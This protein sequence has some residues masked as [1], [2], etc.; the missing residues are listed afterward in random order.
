MRT[1]ASRGEA[2]KKEGKTLNPIVILVSVVI[3][4]TIASYFVFPGM[5]NRT[6]LD[7][8]TV[9][10]AGSY[11]PV[12]KTPVGI[13]EMFR[14]IPEGLV[15]SGSLIWLVLLVGGALKVYTE[16]GS[17]DKGISRFLKLS[18]KVGSQVV[19][20][21]IIIVFALI[22]GFLGWSEQIIPFAPI[23]TAICLS[24]GYDAVV[25]MASAWFVCIIAFSVSPTNMFTVA[26]CQQV[27]ELPLFSGM[28]LRLIILAVFEILC[29]VYILRY[30]AKIKKDPTKSI[31]YDIDNT[32]LRRDYSKVADEKMTVRQ[33]L[34]L[35]ILGLTFV[36]SI[37]MVLAYGWGMNDLATAFLISGLAAGIVCSMPFAKIVTSFADGAKDSFYGALII[38]VARAIQIVLEKGHLVDTIVNVLSNGLGG[39]PA[40]LTAIGVF[41]VVTLINGL[42]PSGSAKAI[43]LMPILV[44]LA[45]MVG[46]TR[47]VATLAYQ[48]GDGISNTFWFT[49]GTLL[50]FLSLNKIPLS[51][52]YKFIVPLEIILCITAAVFLVIA[53]A[54][55]YGPF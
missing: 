51:R 10:V 14:A 23:I 2:V 39:L 15:A 25:G 7:G 55:H 1:E 16:S 5:F 42:I 30:A 52:W 17:L 33:M 43:A 6:Q 41:I 46:I 24:M 26:I 21:F 53:T 47:Q 45:D 3:L 12:D 20:A 4:C 48:F 8:R 38:G 31:V 32:S 44:P 19:L 9:V 29:M 37:Y 50:I 34:S 40:W 54:I 22:G 11:H 27:A 36:I 49:N 18:N 28:N 13:F 35:A